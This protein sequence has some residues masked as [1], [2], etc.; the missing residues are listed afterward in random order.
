MVVVVC[1]RM[2]NNFGEAIRSTVRNKDGIC[3]AIWTISKYV[4]RNNAESLEVQHCLCP[5]AR[6][7]RRKLRAQ[8]KSKIIDNVSYMAGGVGLSDNPEELISIQ[9][10]NIKKTIVSDIHFSVEPIIN[11]IVDVIFVD[12]NHSGINWIENWCKS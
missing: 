1:D 8:R 7:T 3:N 6:M 9:K 5:K 12:D 10:K 2:Q 11:T 4:I